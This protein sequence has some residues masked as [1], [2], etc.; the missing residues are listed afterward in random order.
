M[1]NKL[2][3]FLACTLLLTVSVAHGIGFFENWSSGSFTT[4]NWTFENNQ[5]GNWA[6]ANEFPPYNEVAQFMWSEELNYSYTL[7]SPEFDGSASTSVTLSYSLYYEHYA[8][9]GCEFLNVDVYD[10]SQWQNV[11]NYDNSVQ[12]YGWATETFD[13]SAYTVGHPF[14]IRFRAYG[15]NAYDINWWEIDNVIVNDGEPLPPACVRGH[16][17]FGQDFIP[18]L[19]ATAIV[20]GEAQ[21]TLNDGGMGSNNYGFEFDNL[22]PG[23]HTIYCCS[24]SLE[25]FEYTYNLI[26][27]STIDLNIFLEHRFIYPPCYLEAEA[28]NMTDV[29][30]TW[31]NCESDQTIHFFYDDGSPEFYHDFQGSGTSQVIANKFDITNPIRL[32]SLSY[33]IEFGMSMPMFDNPALECYIVGESGGNPDM[34]NILAGPIEITD[35]PSNNPTD[36]Y[37]VS[38]AVD[39]YIENGQSVFVCLEWQQEVPTANY[40]S[41]G[42]DENLPIANMSIISTDGGITWLP[43]NNPYPF[44]AM[45]RMNAFPT[46]SDEVDNYNIYRNNELVQSVTDTTFIDSGLEAG[47]YTYYVKS[48]YM[49][50]ESLSSPEATVEVGFVANNPPILLEPILH[51]ADNN[52]YVDLNWTN[53]TNSTTSRELIGYNVYR[54]GIQLNNETLPISPCNYR[55]YNIANIQTYEYSVTS[56][57]DEGISEPSNVQPIQILFPPLNFYGLPDQNQAELFWTSPEIPNGYL[58]DGY[59]IYRAGNF[60]CT[61]TDTF[62]IDTDVIPDETYNY[63]ITTL[64]PNGE[65]IQ[66]NNIQVTIGEEVMLPATNLSAEITNQDVALFWDR[67]ANTGEWKSWDDVTVGGSFGL[68]DGATF[69]AAIKLD[70]DDLTGFDNYKL[71][72]IGFFPAGEADYYLKVW[73]SV[74]FSPGEWQLSVD[75]EITEV[76]LNDWNIIEIPEI[77]INEGETEFII[78]IECANY[79]SA[80]LAYDCGPVVCENADMLGEFDNWQHLSSDYAIDANWKI[81]GFLKYS[82]SGGW[83]DNLEDY[84]VIGYNIYRDGEVIAQIPDIEAYF[85]DESLSYGNYS[86]DITVCYNVMNAAILESEH[87]ESVEATILEA[88]LPPENV[89]IDAE[90]GILSWHTPG[91][92]G[93]FEDFEGTYLPEGWLKINHDGGTG[94]EALETGTTPLPGWNGGEA[95]A[96][97]DGGQWQAYATWST[98]GANSN[99]QWLITPQITVEEGDVLDFWLMY[100]FDSYDDHLEVLIST[101]DQNNINAFNVVVDEINLSAGSNTNWTEY[102]YNLTDFISAGTS[103]YIA[104]REVVS[105]NYNAGSALGLDNVLVGSPAEYTSPVISNLNSTHICRKENYVHVPSVHVAES[106]EL[107]SYNVYLNGS[108]II[109]TTE[110]N[111]QYSNLQNGNTYTAGVETVYSSG[112]SEVVNLDFIYSGLNNNFPLIALT[113]LIGNYPNPFNPTTVIRFSLDTAKKVKLEI[114]NVKGAKVKTIINEK[115]DAGDHQVLWDGTNQMNH[116]VASG[117]YFYKMTAGNYEKINKMLLL[118]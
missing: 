7:L 78:G 45:I 65:S 72:R 15:A 24:D 32:K 86:Y 99:D 59:N 46:A 115:L 40:F 41:L 16:V 67:P 80:P 26:P 74:Q 91:N 11:I 39:S 92:N 60:V 73:S 21:L 112:T 51:I 23:N 34:N 44:N 50:I 75:E 85:V 30:L 110:T 93:F 107:E 6:I 81:K 97:P 101:S 14:Q 5:Q 22:E 55:D 114:F 31:P 87:S 105:D 20:D 68:D 12:S 96:C 84:E 98:G 17:M 79:T 1:K 56:V 95:T 48:Q 19:S 58:I 66:T 53:S 89:T 111:Y 113:Q 117:I 18:I 28:I 3:L 108:F 49:G 82:E 102:S 64:Y 83:W 33:F 4:N 104:F 71:N 103:V 27:G 57:Y 54:D 69:I 38:F 100:Y 47:I 77:T 118:K 116:Q 63:R 13:I 62:F 94:W 76:I 43:L 9:T 109:N 61:I 36:P 42:C 88:L 70:T 25:P 29:E 106:R 35:F 10:G 90:T 8:L 2:Q 52:C 37:W